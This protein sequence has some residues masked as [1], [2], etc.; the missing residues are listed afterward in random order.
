V[1]AVTGTGASVISI[2]QF[3]LFGKIILILLMYIGSI[4][5]LTIL[6]GIIFYFTIHTIEWYGLATEILDII[7]ISTISSFFK[8]I[9]F[10]SIFLQIFGVSAFLLLAKSLDI[11]LLFID[12]LFLSINFFCNVGFNIDTLISFDLCNNFWWYLISSILIIIGSCGFLLIFELQELIKNKII[13]KPYSLSITSKLMY[14]IYF[15]SCF[16]FWIFY[17]FVCEDQ[18]SLLSFSR[19]FFAAI[20]LRSCGVSPYLKLPSSIIF[21]SSLYGTMGTAPL[22]TGGGIKTSVLGIIIYTFVSF[23]KK[24]NTVTI[25]FK[26]ISWQLVAIAHIFLLYIMG[27]ATI[28]S[29]IIDLYSYHKIDFLLI[30]SD[31]LGLITGSGALWTDLVREIKIGEKIMCIFLMCFGK[32][33]AIS[34]SLYL[35]KLK[36]SQIKY[37][38][39]KLIII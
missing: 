18:Y 37:P 11:K 27:L 5:I 4:G 1:S 24:E 17:F 39:A 9:F 3:T 19:S 26:K 25:F 23:I 36:K 28:V 6:L 16:M 2:N 21:I 22:G 15:F 10:V 30:Y 20:S 35:S 32:I 7:T 33:A 29:I 31:I 12:A 8:I 38:D 34:L 14:C 13:N